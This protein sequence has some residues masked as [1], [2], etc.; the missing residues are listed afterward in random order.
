[1][2]SY[3]CETLGQICDDLGSNILV[4]CWS[5]NYSECPNCCQWLR[6]HFSYQMCPVVQMF[7]HNDSVF[8]DEN[9]PM[10]T[11][12][13]VQSWFEEHEDALHH[14]PH[15][16][17]LPDLNTIKTLWSI[18]RVGQGAD[19]LLHHLSSNW[20]CSSW[21]AVQYYTGDYS[22]LIWVYSKKDRSFITGKWWS[23]SVLIK[24]CVSFT[25]VSIFFS[26]H[27]ICIVL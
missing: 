5:Y 4:F 12:R 14:F 18:L 26:I 15:P 17:R 20:R 25:T 22:E 3:N 23:N 27:C 21:R 2:P 13:S 24:Q 11:A 9:L 16:A 10:Y 8:Q 19:S 1:M 6:G 7:P